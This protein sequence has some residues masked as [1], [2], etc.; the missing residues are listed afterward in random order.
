MKR[1]IKKLC[2]IAPAIL[3]CVPPALQAAEPLDVPAGEDWKHPHS[4]IVIPARLGGIAR[5][6]ATAFAANFLDIGHQYDSADGDEALS[7]YVFRKTNGSVPVWFEQARWGIENRDIYGHPVLLS[8][9]AAIVPPGGVEASAL[10]A[11][12]AAGEDAQFRSTGIILA[13]YDQ[14][15]VKIRASSM[16]RTPE[17]LSR[18]MDFSFA[19]LLIPSTAQSPAVA[20]IADCEAPLVFKKK[21][22]DAPKDGAANL[23]GGLLGQIAGQLAADDKS[24]GPAAEGSGNPVTW[25]R[26]S[27]VGGNQTVYRANNATDRYLLAFGDNGNAVVVEPDRAA[28]LLQKSSGKSEDRFSITLKT[29]DRNISFVAQNRLPSP[30]RV[31]NIIKAGLST[32]T[33]PTW[34]EKKSIEV[35]SDT[36]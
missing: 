27:V 14:W 7:V 2:I 17:A 16:T 36:F 12:Y 32:V 9:P 20:P 10:K 13:A 19:Q 8:Q 11:V 28:S 30:K 21:A 31:L 26:D 33:I 15:Y 1:A 18:W 23:L 3:L 29:A 6:S 5:S 24:D 4:G 25:C 34:G 35:N 22:K